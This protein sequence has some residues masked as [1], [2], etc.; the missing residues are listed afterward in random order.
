MNSSSKD[1]DKTRG[2]GLNN[3][4]QW[5]GFPFVEY[6]LC[7]IHLFIMF[8]VITTF[9]YRAGTMAILHTPGEKK[10]SPFVGIESIV[11]LIWPT[12]SAGIN[13]NNFWSNVAISL[14]YYTLSHK[15]RY[16]T[17]KQRTGQNWMVKIA[18]SNKYL[19]Y[20][21]NLTCAIDE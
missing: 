6:V 10:L 11:Y 8:S 4:I 18:H 2:K 3:R 20:E 16:E 14:L 12:Y 15:L 1:S 17:N 19:S 9:Y 5:N 21:R 7:A 13:Q